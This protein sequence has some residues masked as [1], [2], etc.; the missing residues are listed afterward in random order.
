LQR[1]DEDFVEVD[2]GE[3]SR[4]EAD[5]EGNHGGV[6]K[7]ALPDEPVGV[8]D[9]LEWNFEKCSLLLEL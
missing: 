5:G 6:R 7:V 2:V 1:R 3:K 8:V 4:V 9:A